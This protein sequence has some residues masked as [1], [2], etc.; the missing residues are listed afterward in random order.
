MARKKAKTAVKTRTAKIKD[1]ISLAAGI[2]M[3]LT[4]L[5][6]GT[7]KILAAG[8]VP[9]QV[10]DFVSNTVPAIFLTPAVISFLINTFIPY[11][12]PWAEFILGA[13]LLIGFLPRLMAILCLPLIFAFLGTNLWTITRGDYTTCASCF[14]IWESYFGSLTPTQS[15]IYD[16]ALMSCATL[17][18]VFHPGKFLT[19]RSWL[20]NLG[21]RHEL[22][23]AP[24]RSK[25]PRIGDR[26]QNLGSKAAN[27]LKLMG[28]KTRQHPRIAA[29]FGILSLGLIACGVIVASTSTAVPKDNATGGTQVATNISFSD[30]SETSAVI[31]WTTDEPTISSVEV[32]SEDGVFIITVT[33]KKLVTKHKLLVAGLTPG[34]TYYFKILS[35]DKQALSQE[36]S[37][38]TLSPAPLIIS[39]VRFYYLT[40]S[41]AT[42]SWVTNRPATSEVEYWESSSKDRLTVSNDKLTTSHS[43]NLA[44]LKAGAI[45]YYQI[46]STDVS[47]NQAVSP[48][49]TMS[50]MIG[51]QA[52]DFTLNSLDGKSVTLS[53]Y[54]GRVVMLDFWIWTCSACRKKLTII[55]EAFNR[56]PP[57]KV[58]IFAIHFEGNETVI[59][60]YVTGA[61]LTVPVLHD[62]TAVVTDL[63]K[64]Y[65]FPTIFIIDNNGFIRMIDPE[66]NTAEELENILKTMIGTK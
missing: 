48:V 37:F 34:T 49:M 16:L 50:A 53:N 3:G 2:F 6:S 58:A 26:L 40:D 31:S 32:F 41:S 66:F 36:H 62:S 1:R 20:A 46:K 61:E 33:E 14:G 65:V 57:E 54:R 42:I 45:Y 22:A 27:W 44:P 24:A 63:Y 21:R 59:R 38:T 28:R 56:M 13:C 52:P 35:A 10:L 17:I 19:S 47:G 39:D 11:V 55:Q 7:G 51:K 30:V 18:I 12:I 60:N 25:A 23:T 8:E 5:A 9:A 15:L 64:V 43:I 29:V 4:L